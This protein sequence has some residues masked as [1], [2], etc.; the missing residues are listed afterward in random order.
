[1]LSQTKVLFCTN[2][3]TALAFAL[4]MP[5]MTLYL[6]NGL[7]IEPGLIGVYT[8]IT[9]GM[10]VL[11]SQ[12]L[13]AL[14]DKGVSPKLLI[15][16]SLLGIIAGSAGFAL[17]SNF[18]HVLIVG[19]LIM[20]LASS[21][22]PLI[23]TVIRRFADATGKSSTKLNSQMRSSVS[24]LWVV[25]PPIAFFSV[26][27]I[28]F[29]SNFYLSAAVAIAVLLLVVSQLRDPQLPP[30]SDDDQRLPALPPV[31]WWLGGIML[32]ANM[33]NSIY[34]SSMPLFVTKDMGLSSAYPG[35]FFG[36][37]AA[38]EIPFM[39]N[40]AS[41][42]N[43]YGKLPMIRLGFVFGML[44]Y[45][46][47]F[48]TDTLWICIALQLVNG[49]FFGIFA[50]LGIT[51]MQDYAPETIG[52]AS[53]FYTNSMLVGTMLGTSL[54]GVIAQYY[55]FKAPLIL[56]LAMLGCALVGLCW[57]ERHFEPRRSQWRQDQANL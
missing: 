24:L 27:K 32:L 25:G 13:T 49:L 29:R 30:K 12:G 37:T 38:V 51:V 8:I 36:L 1:M 44:F 10:T 15:M 45:L 28:G 5:V 18:W 56:S 50:G 53:A 2:G 52:K 11:L 46:G 20:P 48:F 39:L 41:W 26:D 33:A 57:F 47:M 40:V 4:I 43:K 9:S 31:V 7:H 6:V 34:I 42:S 35:V 22:I 55:G 17:S 14:I 23:L 16:L 21:S 19:S 3:L 54:M